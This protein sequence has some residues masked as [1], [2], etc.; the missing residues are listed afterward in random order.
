MLRPSGLSGKHCYPLC[1]VSTAHQSA[2]FYPG[3]PATHCVPLYPLCGLTPPIFTGSLSLPALDDDA[4]TSVAIRPHELRP[5]VVTSSSTRC[6]IAHHL[7]YVSC[8]RLQYYL[9]CYYMAKLS[10]KEVDKNEGV[11]DDIQEQIILIPAF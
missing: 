3:S 2:E 8:D 9:Q 4:V 6:S 11:C 1:S 7:C 10:I 5:L